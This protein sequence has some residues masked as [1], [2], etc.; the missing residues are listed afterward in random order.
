M[1]KLLRRAQFFIL[2]G[3]PQ[4]GFGLTMKT[5]LILVDLQND[6]MPNGALAVPEGDSV[7]PLANALQACFDTVMV[8]QDWHPKNHISFADNHPG[9]TVG[10]VID[11]PDMKQVLWPSHCVQNTEGAQLVKTLQ[12]E[13]KAEIITKGSDPNLDS[14]SGFFDNKYK[15]STNLLIRLNHYQVDT[16]YIM[17]LALDYCVK[18]TVLDACWLG[19]TTFLIEDGCR[20]VNLAPRDSVRAVEAMKAAGATVVQSREVLSRFCVT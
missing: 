3:E 9:K 10:D 11:L 6:F 20:G 5:A 15:K 14:Y 2:V 4:V 16:V 18:Y 17:G 1:A 19:F 12:L 7:I 8:T 13:E